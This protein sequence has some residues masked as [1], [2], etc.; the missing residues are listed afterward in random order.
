MYCKSKKNTSLAY[1]TFYFIFINNI[2]LLCCIA[3]ESE[4]SDKAL[5]SRH[6]SSSFVGSVMVAMM[7]TQ[8]PETESPEDSGVFVFGACFA[9]LPVVICIITG[10]Y[11]H[12]DDA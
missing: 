7:K 8:E 9:L 1:S 2:V 4:C 6:P 12:Y 11:L 5:Q 3:Q 10:C